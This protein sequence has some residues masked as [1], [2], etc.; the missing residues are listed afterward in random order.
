MNWV[1]RGYQHELYV[2]S[3]GLIVGEV[4]YRPGRNEVDAT[5]RQ[6]VH[7]GIGSYITLDRAK[8]AVERAIAAGVALP[9]AGQRQEGG[10]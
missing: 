1:Q 3:A 5:V 2:D 8:A 4:E 7:R 9:L 10:N 6:P